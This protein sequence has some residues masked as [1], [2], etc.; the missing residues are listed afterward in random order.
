[1]TW[2]RLCYCGNMISSMQAGL[3]RRPETAE[4]VPLTSL[5]GIAAMGVVMQHFSTT[6]QQHSNVTIPSLVPHG[7]LAV[8]LFFILSGFIMSYTYLQDFRRRGLQAL[9]SFLGKR[10]ARIVPLNTVVVVLIVTG[11]L[12]SEQ[13]LGRNIFF[14]AR[15]LVVDL[16]TNLLLLQGFGIGTNLNGPSWSISIEFAAY[17]AFPG[18]VWVVFAQR[19]AVAGPVML[20]CCAALGWIASMQPRLGLGTD[21]M[22]FSLVRCIAEFTLGMGCFRVTQHEASARLFMTDAMGFA[23]I[24]GSGFFMLLRLDLL[25]VLL[26]PG[27]IVALATNRGIVARLLSNRALHVLGT[28]SFSLYLIHQFFRSIDLELLQAWHPSPLGKEAAL[29]FA[30]VGSVA[31]IPFALLTYVMVERPGRVLVRRLIRARPAVEALAKS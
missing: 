3:A 23:L 5:R 22:P 25:A 11:G 12:V 8:D 6:A 7:Y 27:L 28:V 1:M 18:L 30:F 26:F 15:D 16:P 20:F 24:A 4:I 31:V 9:G 29:L 14:S 21:V 2:E 13:I 17:C 19:P 10:V